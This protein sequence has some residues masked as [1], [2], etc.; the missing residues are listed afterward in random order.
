MRILIRIKTNIHLNIIILLT[1]YTMNIV[2]SIYQE[3]E[4]SGIPL[5]TIDTYLELSVPIKKIKMTEKLDT[6][7]H[8]YIIPYHKKY[9]KSVIGTLYKDISADDLCNRPDNAYKKKKET[10]SNM[11]M[12]YHQMYIMVTYV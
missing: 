2:E 8:H 10:Q 11:Y 3:L 6:L 12:I 5:Y 1:N 9:S 4:L 7:L